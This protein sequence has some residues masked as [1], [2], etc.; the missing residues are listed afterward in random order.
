MC[1]YSTQNH[2]DALT[3][4]Q[5]AS[6]IHRMRRRKHRFPASVDKS[7]GLNGNNGQSTGSSEG[8]DPS[9]SDLSA[10]TVIYMGPCDDQ[11]DNEHPPVFLPSLSSGDNRCAMQ[12]VLKGSAAE[13]PTKSPVKKAQKRKFRYFSNYLEIYLV[14]IIDDKK[15]T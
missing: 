4:I 15:W 13:K 9:S 6:R 5:L 7:L 1:F 11:T 2:S 8:P 12:K 10:D 3:T 14:F